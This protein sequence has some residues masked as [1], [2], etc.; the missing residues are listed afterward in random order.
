MPKVQTTTFT[1][2]TKF[3]LCQYDF[4]GQKISLPHS[5]IQK[6]VF[7]FKDPYRNRIKA[8]KSLL[9]VFPKPSFNVKLFLPSWAVAIIFSHILIVLICEQSPNDQQYAWELLLSN[10]LSREIKLKIPGE[11]DVSLHSLPL[12]NKQNRINFTMWLL[13][14]INYYTIKAI[15]IRTPSLG[16]EKRGK[17]I[18]GFKKY[19]LMIS[20]VVMALRTAS[21]SPVMH[22]PAVCPEIFPWWQ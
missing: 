11:T 1:F 3:W 5:A 22:V 4:F 19:K 21:L 18:A 10:W 7:I 6:V 20:Q 13:N 12:L 2:S 14:R 9:W 16:Y 8:M 17:T 15:S